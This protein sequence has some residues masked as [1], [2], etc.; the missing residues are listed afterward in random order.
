MPILG[1]NV[2]QSL[3]GT[4]NV[5][6]VGHYLGEAAVSAVANA[7][8]IMYL[9]T[10]ATLGVATAATILVGQC[11]GARKILEAKR[12]VGTGAVVF[13]TLSAA[14][15]V[16]GFLLTEPML[17]AMKTNEAALPLAVSYTEVMFLALPILCLYLYLTS[18]LLGTGDSHTPLWSMMLAVLVGAALNPLLMFGGGPLPGAGIAGSALATLIAQTVSLA[19]LVRHLYRR[20]DPLCLYRNDL[21]L[22]RMDWPIVAEL[23][24]KGVPMGTQILA[25]SL[26]AVIMMALVNRFGVDTSAAYGA[27]LQLWTYI[28]LPAIAIAAAVSSMTAQSVGAQDW[29]RV[30]KTVRAGVIVCALATSLAVI[31]VYVADSYVYRLFLPGDSPALLIASKLN[32]VVMWSFVFL[33]VAIVLFGV[34]RATGVVVAPLL[35]H[36]LSLFAVRFPL[37][38]LLIDRWHADA[39]WWSFSISCAVDFVLAALYYRY[40]GWQS[41]RRVGMVAGLKDTA[42]DEFRA[43]SDD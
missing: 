41:G 29:T 43:G 16:V 12:V 1:M 36:C 22:F 15:S 18:I 8:S 25:V 11:I 26:S 6:W 7:Q 4:M 19:V 34:M 24:R 13:L 9:L 21:A 27:S 33:T 23:F 40:G 3:G 38:L 35:I 2:L 20:R 39:I 42:V 10:G 30:R 37:A 5:F 32:R 14:L 17:L 31:A 28:Q